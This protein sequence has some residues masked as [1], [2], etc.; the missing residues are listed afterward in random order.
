MRSL[1]FTGLMMLSA[2][3]TATLTSSS[4]A[5][6]VAQQKTVLSLPSSYSS[7]TPNLELLAF[8]FG[9][10]AVIGLLSRNVLDKHRHAL[11]LVSEFVSGA[12]FALGLAFSGMTRPSK[13]I[14]FLTPLSVAW[15]PSLMFVMGG[16]LAVATPAYQLVKAA[17]AP[18]PLCEA[19]YSVPKNDNIDNIDKQLV[20]G[21]LLFGAG[22]GYG[23]ICPGPGLV[24]LACFP[25]VPQV[26]AFN[27]AMVGS[28]GI[29]HMMKRREGGKR[30]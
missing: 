30:E 19:D 1:V 11:S 8:T 17:L 12:I 22:W 29:V 7:I 18:A 14:S 25:L 27:V 9:S 16:A 4:V 23:G 3:V 26:L 5:L 21:G 24:N 10:L 13:V 20:L 2:A 28:M 6:G 15:D